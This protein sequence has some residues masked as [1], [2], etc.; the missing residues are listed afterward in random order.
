MPTCVQDAIQRPQTPPVSNTMF[1][2][3]K[4]FLESTADVADDAAA[5][6]DDLRQLQHRLASYRRLVQNINKKALT[7]DPSLSEI[8]LRGWKH[9]IPSLQ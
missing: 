8:S 2:R 6:D 1:T 7:I 5:V 9:S 4:K 3:I